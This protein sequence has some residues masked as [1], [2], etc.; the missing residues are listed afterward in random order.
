MTRRSR[1]NNPTAEM[2]SLYEQ[3]EEMLGEGGAGHAGCRGTGRWPR[4]RCA[5]GTWTAIRRSSGMGPGEIRITAA[6]MRQLAETGEIEIGD[7]QLVW[8]GKDRQDLVRSRGQCAAALYIQEKVHPKA[9]I[10][11]LKRKTTKAREA[12]E[13]AP[14]LFADFNG[15]A[16][17][18]ARAEFY[19]HTKHW[20]NRFILGDSLQVMASL[21]E[22]EEI[23]RQGAVHLFRPPLWHQVQ[24]RTGRSRP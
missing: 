7:A 14:D 21:A 6:Q 16:D 12:T 3:Q 18:E 24:L 20:Q 8:R 13:E 17:P 22:R 1:L 2:A 4:A 19:Q 11:D 9:I 5:S 10:D 23:A 15:I